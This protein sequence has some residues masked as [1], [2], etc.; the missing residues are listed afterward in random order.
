MAKKLPH[1]PNSKI[2]AALRRLWLHS[3]ERSAAIKRDQYTC[4]GCGRK[5][6][7]AKGREFKVEVHHRDGIVNWQAMFDSIREHLLCL[8]DELETLCK[9]CHEKKELS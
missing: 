7:T 2:R 3:R 1:T 9:E 6:S 5:Q 4:Q 8:E